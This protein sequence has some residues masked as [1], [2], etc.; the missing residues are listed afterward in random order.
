[1][2]AKRRMASAKGLVS[3]PSSSTGVMI[4]TM[5]GISGFGSPWGTK[6]MVPMYPFAPSARIPAYSTTKKERTASPTVTEMFAV[7]VAPQGSSPNRFEIRM[8]KKSVITNGTNLSPPCPTL[9]ITTWSRRKST[10][11]STAL[12][13]F[14]GAPV[15]PTRFADPAAVSRRRSTSPAASAMKT[16]CFDGV[17]SIGPTIHDPRSGRWR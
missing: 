8:K 15:A 1:M 11:A 5:I 3:F 12:C 7:A 14:R 6:T 2:L 13:P 4:S 10:S 9:G 17:M 16:T